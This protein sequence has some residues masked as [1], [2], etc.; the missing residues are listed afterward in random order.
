[1]RVV[2][3]LAALAGLSACAGMEVKRDQA[4]TRH[5]MEYMGAT[6]TGAEFHPETQ[7]TRAPA[8]RAWIAV[9]FDAERESLALPIGMNAAAECIVI[10]SGARALEIHGNSQG[11]MTYH[12][13]SVIHPSLMLLDQGYR[14]LANLQDLRMRPDMGFV[15]GFRLRQVVP[16]D[17]QFVEAR[18]A[19]LYVHPLV[20]SGEI[21]V[22]TG[23]QIIPVP[24]GPYGKVR[25]RFL[26]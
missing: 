9:H 17:R 13:L 15:A 25:L 22:D 2:M 18:F 11:G 26:E 16:L 24:F 10:P 8:P 1:M 7:C 4:H 5:A 14:V 20:T 19:V 6:I 12:E 23:Y 3:M 21:E